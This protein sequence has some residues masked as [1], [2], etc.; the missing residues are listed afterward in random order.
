MT[1]LAKNRAIPTTIQ[2]HKD[3]F[4]FVAKYPVEASEVIYEGSF[5]SIDTTGY[6]HVLD[7]TDSQ[8]LGVALE[9]ATG[10]TASGDVS[11]PVGVGGIISHAVTGA[12]AT[13]PG[14]DDIVYALDDQTLTLVAT[15]TLRVGWVVRHDTSTTVWVKLKIPGPPIS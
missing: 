15:A 6:V 8:F 5:V 4:D 9:N 7:T 11:V 14:T 13:T 12:D 2:R 10:G 3:G 1:A